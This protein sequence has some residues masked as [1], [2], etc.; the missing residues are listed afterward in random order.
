M[1]QTH[2]IERRWLLKKIPKNINLDEYKSKLINQ[3]YITKTPVLRLRSEDS[4]EFTL[5]IKTRS[6]SV[7]KK[8]L[9]VPEFNIKLS[10]EEFYNVLP[11]VTTKAIVKRRHYIP[12]PDRMTAEL[13]IFLGDHK[14]LIIVEVE[15]HSEVEAKNFI[16]PTW[17]GK[18]EITG[19]RE[20]SNTNLAIDI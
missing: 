12:L 13:D 20:Y 15:F 1:D 7:N 3:W 4:I 6:K 18:K 11:R 10:A 8:D 16:P 19:N 2:E 17:F 5:T 14:G 9:G